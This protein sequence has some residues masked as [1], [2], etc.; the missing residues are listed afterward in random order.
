MSEKFSKAY[1]MWHQ[2]DNGEFCHAWDVEEKAFLQWKEGGI[3]SSKSVLLPNGLSPRIGSKVACGT[4]GGSVGAPP[5]MK[6][7]LIVHGLP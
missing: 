1:R 5:T 4:C 3:L 2:K 6:K 7:E